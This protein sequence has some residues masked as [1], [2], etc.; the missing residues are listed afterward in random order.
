[1]TPYTIG[2]TGSIGTGKTTTAGMFRRLGIPVH[3][4][5]QEVHQ[6]LEEDE[7]V[8]QSI[9]KIFPF[10]VKDGV[11][12]RLSLG[13]VVF[14]EPEALK[15]LENILHPKVRKR[16]KAFIDEHCRQKTPVVVLDIPLLFEAGYE[17]MCDSI[18]V[19]TC[20]PSIQR[21]R[22]LKRPGMILEKFKKILENQFSSIEKQQRGDYI[23]ETSHGRL[24]TFRRL[25]LVLEK[26]RQDCQRQK[27]LINA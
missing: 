20:S 24:D 25:R 26:M 21:D 6:L 18:I 16:H 9:K 3:E 14:D 11:I 27:D 4:S 10:C 7:G 23:L 8:I 22:V 12:E 5:D 19:T 2:L 1:M 17:G 13:L 15:E